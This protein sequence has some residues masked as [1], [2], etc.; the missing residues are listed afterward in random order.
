MGARERIFGYVQKGLKA[1]L[2]IVAKS[3]SDPWP[4][5]VAEI[6]LREKQLGQEGK[7]FL[8][9]YSSINNS[10]DLDGKYFQGFKVEDL[11]EGK[12]D[13]GG[14]PRQPFPLFDDL[15][16]YLQSNEWTKEEPETAAAT[17]A[18]PEPKPKPKKAKGKTKKKPKKKPST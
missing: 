16:V 2:K 10:V 1:C 15:C 17:E 7:F 4:P 13:P 5:V 12:P 3:L 6:T 14:G 8:C 11:K 18:P 9:V